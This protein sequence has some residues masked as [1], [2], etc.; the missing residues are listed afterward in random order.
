MIDYQYETLLAEVLEKGVIKSDRTGTGTRS[1]FARQLRYDLGTAF[2]MITTK[3][4][5]LKGVVA[6]LIWFLKGSTNIS[7]LVE[8]GVHIWDE[9]ADDNGELGPVYGAQWRS[10]HSDGQSYDQIAQLLQSLQQDPDSRRHLVSAWNVGQLSQMALAPCH[11]FFQC[12]VA[13]GR[14]SLQVYQRSCDL[15]LGVPFNLASYGILTHMLA[16]QSG[17]KVG[18]L[19]WTGGDCHIYLNHVQRVQEQ[20]SRQPFAFP[21]LLLAPAASINDYQISDVTLDN[22]QHH[23][24]IKAPIAV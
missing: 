9:W 4:V 3:K 6:E 15:F 18:E 1:V 24:P 20:L 14:L 12:Y 13:N 2:P 23:P 8:N 11:A 22:Y 10:W 5:F 16:A 19:I 17:L 21:Q 7:Y